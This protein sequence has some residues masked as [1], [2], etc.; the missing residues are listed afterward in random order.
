[1]LHKVLVY[2]EREFSKYLSFQNNISNISFSFKKGYVTDNQLA[3]A[4]KI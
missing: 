4:A 3:Q 1:M 2:Q